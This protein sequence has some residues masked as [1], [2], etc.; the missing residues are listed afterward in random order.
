MWR[1]LTENNSGEIYS[2]QDNLSISSYL[3]G[4]NTIKRVDTDMC[5]YWPFPWKQIIDK[6]IFAEYVIARNDNMTRKDKHNVLA[7]GKG[8]HFL[9]VT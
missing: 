3:S 9:L 6:K 1:S 5:C 7:A 8:Q 4:S 2:I